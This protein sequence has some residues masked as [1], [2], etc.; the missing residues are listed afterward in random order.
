MPKLRDLTDAEAALVRPQ[1]QNEAIVER[2]IE[3][4]QAQLKEQKQRLKEQKAA[5]R[6]LLALLEADADSVAEGKGGALELHGRKGG[7]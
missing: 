7:K 6:Q 4:L 3:R 5:T 2:R 1:M